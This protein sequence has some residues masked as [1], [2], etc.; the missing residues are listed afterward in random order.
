MKFI[1]DFKFLVL[2]GLIS[3]LTVSI[4][5]RHGYQ[6]GTAEGGMPFNNLQRH[7]EIFKWAWGDGAMGNSTSFL[8]ASYPTYLFLS[9]FERIGVPGFLTEAIVFWFILTSSGIG[10]FWVCRKIVNISAGFSLIAVFFYWMSPFVLVNIW[11]RFLYNHIFFLAL[12]PLCFLTYW[13]GIQKKQ[14]SYVFL[15]VLITFIFSYSLTAL[16]LTT[17]LGIVLG[18][19]S[20]FWLLMSKGKFFKFLFLYNL[21]FGIVFGLV[22]AWW[23]SQLL[24]INSSANFNESVASFFSTEGN[25]SGLTDISRKL[26]SLIDLTRFIHFSFFYDRSSIWSESFIIKPAL[27]LNSIILGTV[28]SGIVMARKNRQILFF[29]LFFLISLFLSKGNSPPFGEL[30]TYFFVK[31]PFLQIFRNPIE[32]IGLITVFS[33]SILFAYALE[34]FHHRFTENIIQKFNG[35]N[36][37]VV[38]IILF[39]SIFWG[40]PFFTGLT[41]SIYKNNLG[42]IGNYESLVPD[43]YKAADEAITNDPSVLR[44]LALPL[45]GEGIT[46]NWPVSYNGIDIYSTLFRKQNIALNTTIPFYFEVINALISHQQTTELIRFLPYLAIDKIVLRRD[47]DFKKR[48]YPDPALIEKALIQLV[49]QGKLKKTADYGELTVFSVQSP[50]KWGK[51]YSTNQIIYSNG[52]DFAKLT[53][54]SS[55]GKKVFVD[56]YLIKNL[57]LDPVELL[58]YPYKVTTYTWLKKSQSL[59][60]EDLYAKLLY[61]KH[62]PDDV[63]Y[64]FVRS[65]ELLT[66]LLY[67]DY[68]KW[69]LFN[70]DILGKRAVELCR[71]QSTS[72]N[73]EMENK[74]LLNYQSKFGEMKD[75][76]KRIS[77]ENRTLK[78]EILESLISQAILL[79]RCQ[80]I[81]FDYFY[82]FF[83]DIGIIPYTADTSAL[84]SDLI[85]I[86]YKI[87]QSG[88]YVKKDL[89]IKNVNSTQFL[90]KGD[91]TVQFADDEAYK[92]QIIKNVS[93]IT[94][95]Y[96]WDD[97]L[98]IEI[99]DYAAEYIIKVNYEVLDG[100]FMGMYVKQNTDSDFNPRLFASM[101]LSEKNNQFTITFSPSMGAKYINIGISGE[102]KNLCKEKCQFVQNKLKIHIN[103]LQVTK[104]SAIRPYF[105]L[106]KNKPLVESPISWKKISPV[107]YQLTVQKTSQDPEIL[108]FSEL[109][110]SGWTMKSQQ[111]QHIL[112][113]GYAN[114]WI[115]DQ[116]GSFTTTVYYTPQ[117]NL[118]LGYI[119]SLSATLVTLIFFLGVKKYENTK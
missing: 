48:D 45:L 95:D 52:L 87:P 63:I 62:S 39:I 26:G 49:E 47:I 61:V 98:P 92:E 55:A 85:D 66:S 57:S 60:D 58:L 81:D 30:Y 86:L 80:K 44:F 43:Y 72:Q 38:F 119:V 82:P 93:D 76:I 25:I 54:A 88:N 106:K 99:D 118:D 34:I 116:P 14:Y 41:F 13:I 46:Y 35:R 112:V 1:S 33:A 101:P 105:T 9:Q 2:I 67:A 10:I 50:Y 73:S 83:I 22:H 36:Y 69:V 96:Q 59:S 12:L 114:G 20:L 104:K 64:P 7:A 110:G 4:W 19:V 5:F 8:V 40:W 90:A 75:H 78:K 31:A 17:L 21:L 84:K 102:K 3:L 97:Q 51:F 79:E 115:L 16:A 53:E 15:T 11:N 27:L 108:V 18:F 77:I 111:F 100:D 107:E 71:Y 109:F 28:L 6:L 68:P 94:F 89:S 37:L 103:S 117:S 113:N 32:K 24:F 29:G 74:L 91:Y 70:T 65:K 23:L 56:P 42:E